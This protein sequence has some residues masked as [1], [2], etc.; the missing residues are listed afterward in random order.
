MARQSAKLFIKCPSSI[1]KGYYFLTVRPYPVHGVRYNYVLC[2]K[3][4]RKLKPF[5]RGRRKMLC[6][7]FPRKSG[8]PKVED[9]HRL[10]AFNHRKCN[11]KRLAW[12]SSVHVH[13]HT[14][15]QPHPTQLTQPTQP[16]TP[17]KATSV[18]TDTQPFQ[19]K[20]WLQ[21]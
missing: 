6:H 9:L 7:L 3:H 15:T 8:P 13:N 5:D 16:T 4:G 20:E 11:W 12:S 21:E 17:P 10:F 19:K 18:R 1:K 2:N 14:T